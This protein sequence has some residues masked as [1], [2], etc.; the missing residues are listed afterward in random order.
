MKQHTKR[1]ASFVLALFFLTFS[2]VAY[3]GY[4]RGA[5]AEITKLRSDQASKAELLAKQNAVL[6]TFSKLILTANDPNGARAREAIALAL[7]LEEDMPGAVAQIY[8]TAEASGLTLQSVGI[9][10]ES[11]SAEN[12]APS[13]KRVPLSARVLV[14]RAGTLPFKVRASGSYE[15]LK[16]FLSALEANVRVFT[17]GELAISPAGRPDQDSYTFDFTVV[18]YYQTI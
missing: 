9:S 1:F 13:G 11:A 14:K 15:G 7:P 10:G 4:I 12:R 5:Y 2:M 3:F 16:K 18:A 17:V 6:D 8:G